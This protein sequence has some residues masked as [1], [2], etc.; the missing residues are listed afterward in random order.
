[1][2]CNIKRTL[3]L[4]HIFIIGIFSF[5]TTSDAKENSQNLKDIQTLEQT[6][7]ES[8]ISVQQ[9]N[10]LLEELKDSKHRATAKAKL[11][12]NC[13]Q[14]IQRMIDFALVCDNLE[15]R[16]AC[17]DII[18]ALDASYQTTANGKALQK[19][20]QNQAAQLLPEYWKRFQKNSNDHRAVAF[21]M[22]VD[23]K[24]TYAWLKTYKGHDRHDQIR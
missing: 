16:Q 1:M 7:F 20:Y 14:H 5:Q 6:L 9:I 13:H 2:I 4:S 8:D 21:L 10:Q 3:L 17:A 19:L 24:K 18:E 22:A 12:Q 23:A 11:S 15:A